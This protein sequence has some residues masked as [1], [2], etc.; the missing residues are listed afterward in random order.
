MGPEQAQTVRVAAAQAIRDQ[1]SQRP[2]S[3]PGGLVDI[4]DDIIGPSPI[5]WQ[6]L[7]TAA[8]RRPVAFR[9]GPTHTS[10]RKVDRRRHNQ[11]LTRGGGSLAGRAV[12]PGRVT[13][14]VTIAFIRDTSDSMRSR[15]LAQVSA[16][17]TQLADKLGIRDRELMVLDADTQVHTAAGYRGSSS[18]RTV[19]G[20]S[21]TSMT[22]A[23]QQA[24]ELTPAPAVVVVATDDET[25]W[26]SQPGRCPVVAVLVTRGGTLPRWCPAPA[27][28]ITTVYADLGRTHVPAP[29]RRYVGA[30]F[31]VGAWPLSTRAATDTPPTAG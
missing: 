20:R 10:Y 31:T 23:I 14:K 2:G 8:I 19:T 21:G 6:R 5:P 16:E 27:D 30:P 24:W 15:Q 9:R 29:S 25:G 12:Y 13:P 7:L 11:R 3:V 17:I 1:A 4:A 22:T 28:W 26:P 18:I